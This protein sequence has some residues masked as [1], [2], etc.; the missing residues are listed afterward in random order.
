MSETQSTPNLQ[1]GDLV[2]WRP[3]M[4]SSRGRVKTAVVLDVLGQVGSRHD[5]PGK[6]VILMDGQRKEAWEDQLKPLN[7]TPTTEPTH[8]T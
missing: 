2:L 4:G 7:A 6:V 5:I 1:P 8:A 3:L